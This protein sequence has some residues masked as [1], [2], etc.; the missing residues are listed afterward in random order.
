MSKA[1][2]DGTTRF[3][4]RNGLAD[5]FYN[6]VEDLYISSVGLGTF[7][8]EPYKE[9][10]Y[11]FSYENA[12]IEAVKNGVNLIDTASNYR[13][14]QSEKEIGWALKK[15]FEQNIAK[16]DE[17][18][19]CSKGGFIQ[20]QYP[21]PQNPYTW[22]KDNIIHKNLG[23]EADISLDQHC[24][25]PKFVD[26]SFEKS[27]QYLGV[28]AIDIYYVHNIEMQF[29]QMTNE[30]IFDNTKEIFNVLEQKV[31]D[32]K[33][34]Y[35][36]LAGWNGLLNEPNNPEYISL[37]NVVDLAG[38]GFKFLQVPFNLAKTHAYSVKN[39]EIDGEM[40][41]LFEAAQKLGLH[42]ITS[43]SFLQTNL[44]KRPFNQAVSKLLGAEFSDFQKA[45]RFCAASPSACA[46]F[47]SKDPEHVKSNLEIAKKQKVSKKNF[48]ALF[49]V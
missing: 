35:Y 28:D 29:G 27:L 24:L 9:E 44:F 34:S 2:L 23:T 37:K 22:I 6:K 49:G 32:G 19:V 3:S 20:L 14:T 41:T 12:V 1:T 17:L 8:P 26:F 33:L 10:N 16:R 39:Q 5:D 21:F 18:V 40:Y 30:Q 13:Y 38:S 43:S 48:E 46:L 25:T 11:E 45:L 36:G 15:I 47:G 4:N 42:V 31:K 7:I